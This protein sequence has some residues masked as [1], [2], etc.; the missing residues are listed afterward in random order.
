MEK[1]EDIGYIFQYPEHQI[2]ETTIFKDISYGLK[3]LKLNEIENFT[4]S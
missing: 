4:K 3:K 2:F 1:I